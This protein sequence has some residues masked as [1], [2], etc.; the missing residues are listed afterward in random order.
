MHTAPVQFQAVEVKFSGLEVKFRPA[1]VKNSLISGKPPTY[2][3]PSRLIF[4]KSWS[5]ISASVS[6]GTI[7]GFK[8]LHS[9]HALPPC[10]KISISIESAINYHSPIVMELP[11]SVGQYD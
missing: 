3:N 9:F 5:T 8:L 10:F 2:S 11:E 4:V 6:L 1:L 7:D